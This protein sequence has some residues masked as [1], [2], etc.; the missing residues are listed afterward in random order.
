MLQYLEFGKKSACYLDF[1][2]TEGEYLTENKIQSTG[3][4][5]A[6]LN[7]RIYKTS[8]SEPQIDDRSM[9]PVI[10]EYRIK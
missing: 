7:S 10:T 5:A 1:C 8:Q 6:A 3:L 2:T 4:I 9:N